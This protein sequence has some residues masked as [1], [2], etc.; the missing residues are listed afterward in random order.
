VV[1][2]PPGYP[3]YAILAHAFT[4]L[5]VE[6][7]L[8][9]NLMSATFGVVGAVLL[10]AFALR[11]QTGR[12]PAFVAAAM[13]GVSPT[14]WNNAV[15]A[16][17]YTPG[18]AWGLV[19]LWLVHH[20]MVR[21][22]L[23]A[24]WAS[25]FVGGTSLGMHMSVATMGLGFAVWL[26][27]ACFVRRDDRW[28][29]DR[30]FA[31]R[32]VVGCVALCAVGASVLLLVPWGPFEEVTPLRPTPTSPARMWEAFTANVRGGIFQGYFRD[33]P[34]GERLHRI[35]VAAA[36]SLT[37][38]GA[39]AGVVG[40][41]AWPA[42]IIVIGLVAIVLGNVGW[43]Y[44]YDVPD[45]E[46]FLLP[47]VVVLCLGVAFALHRIERA[48]AGRFGPR[49]RFVPAVGLGIPIALAVTA[50]PAVD[51]SEARDAADY[52]RA[53]CDA[54]PPEAILAMTSRPDEWR[55]YTVVFYMHETGLG[56]ESTELWGFT[57][58]PQIDRALDQGRRVFTFVSD[59][60]FAAPY[61]L[62][63][64]GP[65]WEIHRPEA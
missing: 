43:F 48:A 42:R 30:P 28:G 32:L 18:L 4:W 61:T 3:L 49:A 20:A 2:H 14:W 63:P 60:R 56:C 22:S 9:V 34:T 27:R 64:H 31:V 1:P 26:G 12:L 19:T 45:L 57:E 36:T 55:R 47:S 35:A 37:A 38:V 21:R 33:F 15:V 11:L 23:R 51:K 41:A 46:V 6:P 40:L 8:G 25:A 58:R 53:A 17:V 54:L 52:G 13:L 29:F 62:R 24:A 59:P 65:L 50:Y 16:E 39:V 5:P 44:R 10:Y 7:A